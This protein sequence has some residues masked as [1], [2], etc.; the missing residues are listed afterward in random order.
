MP[1]PP[2]ARAS[3]AQVRRRHGQALHN[4]SSMLHSSTARDC[5]TTGA[6]RDEAVSRG[7]K[8]ARVRTHVGD[9]DLRKILGSLGIPQQ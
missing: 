9:A 1:P 8:T 3:R 6:A 2:P 4:C 7:R 5:R